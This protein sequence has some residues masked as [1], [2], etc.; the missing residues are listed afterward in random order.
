MKLRIDMNLAPA[1]VELFTQHGHDAVHWSSVGDPRAS[2]H[3]LMAWALQH[4]YVVVTHDLDFGA[5]L[6]ATGARGPSVIQLR[7]H[8]ILPERAGATVL[9]AVAQ[10]TAQLEAGALISIDPVSARARILPIS[11]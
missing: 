9:Q 3:T 11:R 6:A 7:T 1:W 8:N 10:F 2:D 5:I 4:G